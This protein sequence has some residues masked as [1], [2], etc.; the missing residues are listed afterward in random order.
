MTAREP[1]TPEE[2]ALAARLARLGP[3]GEPSPALDA[4]ILAA[5]RAETDAAPAAAVRR[6]A[7][8]PWAFGIAASVALAVGLAWQLRPLPGPVAYEEAASAQVVAAPEATEQSSQAEGDDAAA[9]ATT[10]V[11]EANDAADAAAPAVET[12][13]SP[14]AMPPMEKPMPRVLSAPR[15]GPP[16]RDPP[17]SERVPVPVAPPP[18][19]VESPAAAAADMA[20]PEPP[21]AAPAPS[22]R[23]PPPASSTKAAT[24]APTAF[25][26][27][28]V[29][30]A[31][32]R[33]H[34]IDT[35]AETQA[36]PVPVPHGEPEVGDV[37]PATVDSPHVREAWLF[38][39]RELRD[40]GRLEEARDSLME[41]VARY[42]RHDV[43]DDLEPLFD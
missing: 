42:P 24:P 13:A 5:A 41:Y 37:P 27:V 35:A 21:P 4:R 36:A 22:P 3:H 8:W 16:R 43:P 23:P 29:R 18:P 34:A 32:T 1:L 15:P 19:V 26:Q 39:I 6:P 17:A 9:Q 33:R 30:D 28:P 14:A 38:R 20:L 40:A 25:P 11:A 2:Q 10:G 7:R 12:Y 31:T